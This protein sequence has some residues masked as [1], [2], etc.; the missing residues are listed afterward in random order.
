MCIGENHVTD[1]HGHETPAE[2]MQEGR[3][4][5]I[6]ESVGLIRFCKLATVSDYHRFSQIP[7]GG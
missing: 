7:E 6:A 1:R 2:S 3:L 4:S 5:A